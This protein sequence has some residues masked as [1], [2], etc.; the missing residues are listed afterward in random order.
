M[1]CLEQS[2]YPDRDRDHGGDRDRG[3]G[4]DRDRDND[5]DR[6]K[7][8]PSTGLHNYAS[9]VFCGLMMTVPFCTIWYGVA[10][11]W[12][13]ELR[14]FKLLLHEQGRYQVVVMYL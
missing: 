14:G 3:H 12:A 4:G 10:S 5:R 13:L 6:A 1:M 9:P 8:H 7:N 2:R 11:A